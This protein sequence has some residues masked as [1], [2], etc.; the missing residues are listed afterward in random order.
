MIISKSSKKMSSPTQN[1]K[2]S[3]G[4]SPNSTPLAKID[5]SFVSKE[6][7]KNILLSSASQS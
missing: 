5:L 3:T 1:S 2:I 7:T 4:K 6:T